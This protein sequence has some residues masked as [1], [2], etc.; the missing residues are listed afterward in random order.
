[1]TGLPDCGKGG[2]SAGL[3]LGSAPKVGVFVLQTLELPEHELERDQKQ[4]R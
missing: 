1:M 4:R 3:R 2:L